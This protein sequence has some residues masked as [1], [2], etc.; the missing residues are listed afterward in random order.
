S[1]EIGDSQALLIGSWQM[2]A[3]E[4]DWR[5]EPALAPKRRGRLVVAL[6]AACVAAGAGLG[7][8][9]AV[10]RLVGGLRPHGG[11]PPPPAPLRGAEARRAVTAAAPPAAPHPGP[12]PEVVVINRATTQP[13]A[14]DQS[15]PASPDA[16]TALRSAAIDAKR[17][18]ARHRDTSDRRVLVVVRRK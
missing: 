5:P 11:P 8:P 1:R 12:A 3:R 7:W 15:N 17:P 10:G 14:G 18:S 4:F 2:A 13:G 16:R 9:A 6:L